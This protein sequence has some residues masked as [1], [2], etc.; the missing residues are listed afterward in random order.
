MFACGYV[1]MNVG[2]FGDSGLQTLGIR[3]LELELEILTSMWVFGIESGSSGRLTSA[4][5][6]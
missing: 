1:C 6:N 4:L 5:N 3:P 2:A